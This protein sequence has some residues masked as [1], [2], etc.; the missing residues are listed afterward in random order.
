MAVATAFNLVNNPKKLSVQIDPGYD[1]ILREGELTV[2]HGKNLKSVMRVLEDGFP[3]HAK[4]FCP[5]TVER[6]AET[7]ALRKVIS[8]GFMHAADAG[9]KRDALAN[10]KEDLGITPDTFKC[11]KWIAEDEAV[12]SERFSIFTAGLVASD[13]ITPPAED[14]VFPPSYFVMGTPEELENMKQQV[15]GAAVD[16]VALLDRDAVYRIGLCVLRHG[17]DMVRVCFLS[18]NK[19]GTNWGKL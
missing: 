15:D 8:L 1:R 14:A 11:E 5:G 3:P 7:G 16:F 19:T 13:A 2:N 4:L 17:I 9:S 18:R 6:N 12:P 10:M